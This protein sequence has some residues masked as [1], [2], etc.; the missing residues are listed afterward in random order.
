[1]KKDLLSKPTKDVHLRVQE[2][3]S[4]QHIDEVAASRDTKVNQIEEE[5]WRRDQAILRRAAEHNA[6]LRNE[7]KVTS[8]PSVRG[9]YLT[10]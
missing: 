2:K 3:Y 9:F 1:M 10:K 4:S 5:R 8:T 7:T 6:H